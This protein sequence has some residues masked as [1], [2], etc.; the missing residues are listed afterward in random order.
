MEAAERNLGRVLRD[1]GDEKKP[2]AGKRGVLSPVVRIGNVKEC[3]PRDGRV[4]SM[5]GCRLRNSCHILS[6]VS[7]TAIEEM[8]DD[9]FARIA[10]DHSDGLTRLR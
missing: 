7:G 6:S 9:D 1:N 10:A 8:N 5:L 2:I 3:C 4:V